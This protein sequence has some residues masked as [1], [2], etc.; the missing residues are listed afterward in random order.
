MLCCNASRATADLI[1][2]L[3]ENR[4]LSNRGTL[5]FR[6]RSRNAFWVA[7][8]SAPMV[9]SCSISVKSSVPAACARNVLLRF[10]NDDTHC[11]RTEP[12]PI[13]KL[14]EISHQCRRCY[15]C[16]CLMT[17][18]FTLG[19]GQQICF[20]LGLVLLSNRYTTTKHTSADPHPK[21][22]R[23]HAAPRHDV[24]PVVAAHLHEI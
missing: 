13:P 17:I 9:D 23:L 11:L 8:P 6:S 4:A 3:K 10:V 24:W 20:T 7:W 19:V 2:Q 18:V 22:T 5:S 1:K 16:S 14:N 15:T 21:S 12:T